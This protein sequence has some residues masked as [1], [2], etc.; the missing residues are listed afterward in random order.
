[1]WEDNGATYLKRLAVQPLKNVSAYVRN[2]TEEHFG[3]SSGPVPG[4]KGTGVMYVDT[5]GTQAQEEQWA[6]DAIR[7]WA[8]Q[9]VQGIAGQSAPPP[10][11][12]TYPQPYFASI[13]R[14]WARQ[15]YWVVDPRV[16][17]IDEEFLGQPNLPAYVGTVNQQ[18][19][20]S[21]AVSS[22]AGTL[23]FLYFFSAGGSG[24]GR[25]MKGG[26]FSPTL[27][28]TYSTAAPV[29]G[30]V[31]LP[32]V[33]LWIFS[34]R[35]SIFDPAQHAAFAVNIPSNLGMNA[36]YFEASTVRN[37]D[38]SLQSYHDTPSQLVT[39]SDGVSTTAWPGEDQLHHFAG[40][41]FLGTFM[42]ANQWVLVRQKHYEYQ[43]LETTGD[44]PKKSN[45]GD[46]DLGL[47]ADDIG[48]AYQANPGYS[49]DPQIKIWQDLSAT[50]PTAFSNDGRTI[51]P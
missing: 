39:R 24:A 16:V 19:G 41:F 25:G 10:V 26:M 28:T 23:D 31:A 18:Y 40:Y 7:L 30:A 48:Q 11:L 5:G 50:S 12:T 13:A 17:P 33:Y 29:P 21:A 38:G 1:D 44:W 42:R 3:Y 32:D 46:Y 36:D 2:Y 20:G 8:N 43:A 45:P 47:V 15:Y 4:T 37:P 35:D 14:E 27:E 6:L 9:G 49:T 22:L 34:N 51:F